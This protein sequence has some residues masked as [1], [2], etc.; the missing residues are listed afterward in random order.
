LA[1]RSLE[2]PTSMIKHV[3]IIGHGAIGSLWAYYLNKSG[4][5][6]SVVGRSANSPKISLKV[7]LPNLTHDVVTLDYYQQQLPPRYDLVL[8]TTKAYQVPAALSPFL[9]Q[10]A[11]TPIVLLHNGMGSVE[12]LTL[13][14]SQ[15]IMLATTSHGA[16]KADP[17]TLCHTGLGETF[18]GRYQGIST[19]QTQAI[20]TL[21]DR[22]LPK[23][24]YCQDIKRALWQKLAINCAINPLTA[25]EQCRNGQLSEARFQA[26]IDQVCHEVSLLTAKL[27]IDL[28]Y[29]EIRQS[30]NQV[31]AKTANNFSSM[32]QDIEHNRV[33]EIDFIS[34]YVVSQGQSLGIETPKNK[35]LWQAVKQLELSSG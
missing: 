4:L 35:A 31:I 3:T 1:A 33:S 5:Q 6:V 9:A 20:A 7:E 32:Q 14:P 19:A 18:I 34:G 30:V 15:S 2:A 24:S 23:V 16:F 21:L 11:T 25:I 22:A 28:N 10:L 27:N 29:Q 13:A 26:S 8:V 12:R 17:T